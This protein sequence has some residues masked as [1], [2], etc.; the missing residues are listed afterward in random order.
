M[1]SLSL[2]ILLC[3]ILLQNGQAST[4]GQS[5]PRHLASNGD[6]R[7]LQ[8]V[9]TENI[10]IVASG[11]SSCINDN[12]CPASE[13]CLNSFCSIKKCI[14]NRD[15]FP[16]INGIR[17]CGN[18]QCVHEPCELNLTCRDGYYCNKKACTVMLCSSN[19]DCK[20]N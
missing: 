10:P 12:Q 15:C 1:K 6:N 8:A 16:D 9:R 17:V 14:S 20:E 7:Q 5:Q 19:A 11:P 18:F 2:P 4:I 3:C 13:Y